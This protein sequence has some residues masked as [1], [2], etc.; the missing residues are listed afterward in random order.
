MNLTLFLWVLLA[1][2]LAALCAEPHYINGQHNDAYH[3]S[4]R[5]RKIQEDEARNART[6]P[7]VYIKTKI[8]KHPVFVFSKSYCPYCK[9]VKNLLY[10]QGVHY[11]SI[12]LDI[13]EAGGEVQREL[14]G[15]TGQ[16]TVPNVFVGGV[17]IGGADGIV[18]ESG[19]FFFFFFFFFF[20][21]RFFPAF[22]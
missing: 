17:S 18:D 4:E 22:D 8:A 6:H 1:A 5:N 11:A 20:S 13:F 2:P 21:S 3:K 12:E 16:G 19:F 10:A 7:D 14:K 15:M 9:R